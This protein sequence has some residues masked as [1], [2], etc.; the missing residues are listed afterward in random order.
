MFGFGL[1]LGLSVKGS[2]NFPIP[3]QS[4]SPVVESANLLPLMPG[5]KINGSTGVGVGVGVGLGGGGGGGVGVAV[6]SGV[7]VG[8]GVGCAPTRSVTVATFEHA[9]KSSQ[10]L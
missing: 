8:V 9:P 3:G 5:I 2:W 6:G 7:G 4:S 10:I 1:S